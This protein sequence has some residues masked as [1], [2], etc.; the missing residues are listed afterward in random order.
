[1]VSTLL[2]PKFINNSFY[3]RESNSGGA[4]KILIAPLDLV[5]DDF[6]PP[7]RLTLFAPWVAEQRETP[8][9]PILL[10]VSEQN[11][12][13]AQTANLFGNRVVQGGPLRVA[14]TRLWLDTMLGLM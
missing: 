4:I 2:V 8:F 3:A 5:A 11:L 12:V 7:Q 13:A 10:F 14:D 9:N 6:I 1:M